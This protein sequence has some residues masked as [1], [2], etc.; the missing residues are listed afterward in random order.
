MSELLKPFEAARLAGV[1]YPTLKQWI[2]KG[3]I[4]STKTAGGHHRIARSEIERV[5]GAPAQ[6]G[7]ARQAGWVRS[8]QRAQQ[9]A[10]RY[11]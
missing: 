11:F 1:S 8:H 6:A 10:R 4:R 2:Y 5:T 7:A 9:V 3:K